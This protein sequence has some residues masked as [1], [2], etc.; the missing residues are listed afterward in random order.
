MSKQ[1]WSKNLIC[2]AWMFCALAS[3]H[4]TAPAD[5]QS[6]Y[7]NAVCEF[8]DAVLAH[9]RDTYGDEQSPLFVDGLHVET[10]RPAV[11]KWDDENWVLSNLAS[12]QPLL[13]TLDGLTALTGREQYRRAAEDAV[14]YALDHTA[15]PNGL[16]YW[17]GHFAWDLEGDR[18]VGQYRDVHELKNHQ[19]YFRLMWR[20]NPEATERLMEAIWAAHVLDWSRLDY[21]RHA[22]VTRPVR[23][24]WNHPFQEEVEVPFPAQ[25]NNLSFVN[26]TPPL[27]HS[28][29]ML[30]VLDENKAALKWTRRL[31][32]RW[33]QA[34][35]PRTGLSGGQLSYRAHDR[36]QDALGHV[37]PAI[38]EAK[39]VASYHQTNRYHDLPLAQMQAALALQEKGGAYAEAG[40]EFMTWACDDLK[41]YARYSF[42]PN[43]GLFAAVM[44]DGTP[45]EWEKARSDYYVPRSFAPRR[46]DGFIFW[47]YALAYRLTGDQVHWQMVR[48]LAESL[49]L[50][51]TGGPGGT[52]RSLRLDTES[53]DWR[54]IYALLEL[55]RA[56]RDEG[57]LNLAARVADNILALQTGRGLFPRAGRRWAR[58]GDEMPLA[59]LH[60][61]ATLAGK[62][63]LM[64]APMRDSRF[65]HCEYRG[66]LE[67]HQR[68][69]ADRR[70]YDNNVF[71]GGS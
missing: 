20:V 49:S 29:A 14:R 33:Q 34:E 46:P 55:H 24:Q 53:R 64:P 45:L 16:L 19:P 52:Q 10:L 32:H 17:G 67:D 2:L 38:N 61:A 13:R 43:T 51:D 63:E 66:P 41:A 68:K 50:G 27:L 35:H 70:T 44:I 59:V 11:W 69:R 36:A 56:T 40:R 8:T 54:L 22:S 26:V 31:L 7:V 58:T 57:F 42:D 48:R 9:G 37:H 62:S 1:E 28:G 30:A 12:Q 15:T 39:I 6:R 47:G 21:N 71:Y 3:A 18:P 60:L 65:F 25:G 4:G 5:R 23:P